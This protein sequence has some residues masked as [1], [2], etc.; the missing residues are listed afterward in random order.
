M[1]VKVLSDIIPTTECFSSCYTMHS[2]RERGEVIYIYIYSPLS[3]DSFRKQDN[4][5]IVSYWAVYVDLLTACKLRPTL[6]S[7]FIKAASFEQRRPVLQELRSIY[8][9]MLLLSHLVSVARH[10]SKLAH[11]C[12]HARLR[13]LG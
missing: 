8:F 10:D 7:I 13:R 1:Q 3:S 12:S 2:Q 4:L 11:T 5:P 9:R 6:S